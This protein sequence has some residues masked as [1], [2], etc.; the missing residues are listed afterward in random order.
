MSFTSI[1]GNDSK[2]YSITM[3][4][5]TTEYSLDFDIVNKFKNELLEN[6]LCCINSEDR[7]PNFNIPTLIEYFEKQREEREGKQQ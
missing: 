5:N 1:Y 3:D 6:L 4:F 2:I 7:T